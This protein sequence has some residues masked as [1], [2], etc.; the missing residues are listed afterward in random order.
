MLFDL[1][2]N[3][4]FLYVAEVDTAVVAP[5]VVAADVVTPAVLA[6]A[7]VAAGVVVSEGE[8]QALETLLHV[9]GPQL[10]RLNS[11]HLPPHC[12]EHA[13]LAQATWHLLLTEGQQNIPKK[14]LKYALSFYSFDNNL[15]FIIYLST[16][17]D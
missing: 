8:L 7:V 6:A 4:Y 15:S 10:F 14:N 11:P 12:D 9:Y 3:F 16:T 1:V 13:L 5:A 17:C 2:H